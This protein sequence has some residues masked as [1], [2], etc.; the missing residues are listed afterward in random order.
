MRT[1]L[2]DCLIFVA[3]KMRA[4]LGG[5]LL[6]L[7]ALLATPAANLLQHKG[8]EPTPIEH[9]GFHLPESI[10]P[11]GQLYNVRYKDK[12][13]TLR[14]SVNPAAAAA[15]GGWSPGLNPEV[16]TQVGAAVCISGQVR[17]L[18][19]TYHS[20]GKLRDAFPGEPARWR[21][22]SSHAPYHR[23]LSNFQQQRWRAGWQLTRG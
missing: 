22:H 12:Q 1:A 16:S 14:S 4:A 20:I 9:D 18:L 3:D 15:G 17:T 8:V 5:R 11:D 19:E 6:C 21:C 7:A 2:A 10:R 13:Y 23:P